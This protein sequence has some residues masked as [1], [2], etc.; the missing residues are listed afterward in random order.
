MEK[1][2]KDCF[3]EDGSFIIK[4]FDPFH[5]YKEEERWLYDMLFDDDGNAHMVMVYAAENF[6]KEHNCL[7]NSDIAKYT[8][9]SKISCFTHCNYPDFCLW[10]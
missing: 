2:I 6:A 5:S 3:T 1:L 7:W 9:C 8:L 10:R 4:G